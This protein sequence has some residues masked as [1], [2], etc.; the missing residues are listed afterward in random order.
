MVKL[1]QRKGVVKTTTLQP[2]NTLGKCL[3]CGNKA[4]LTQHHIIPQRHNPEK[5]AIVLICVE[6]HNII[7][8]LESQDTLEIKRL[9]DEVRRLNILIKERNQEL[10]NVKGIIGKVRNMVC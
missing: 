7:N 9:N 5:N 2:G 10:T 4:F 6:C 8:Q 1:N 3:V